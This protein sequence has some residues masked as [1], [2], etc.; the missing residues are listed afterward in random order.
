LDQ[1]DDIHHRPVG[2]FIHERIPSCQHDFA[3][4]RLANSNIPPKSPICLE[5]LEEEKVDR[6][7]RPSKSL[8]RLTVVPNA[9][10][11]GW[12]LIFSPAEDLHT[13]QVAPERRSNTATAAPSCWRYDLF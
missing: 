12:P 1:A 3:A 4:I 8:V 5:P 9:P 11:D 6:G 13:A 2:V 7:P 10:P